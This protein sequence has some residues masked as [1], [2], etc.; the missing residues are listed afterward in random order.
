VKPE[1][2]AEAIAFLCDPRSA[3]VNGSVVTLPSM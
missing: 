2:V 3:A 1:D